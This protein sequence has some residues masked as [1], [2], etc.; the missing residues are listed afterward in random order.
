MV[1]EHHHHHNIHH[2]TRTAK[3]THFK[4]IGHMLITASHSVNR[5]PPSDKS[6]TKK[7]CDCWRLEEK[8][9]AS[10]VIGLEPRVKLTYIHTIFTVH[11]ETSTSSRIA[12]AYQSCTI[13]TP[14][15]HCLFGRPIGQQSDR[16]RS[17]GW[18]Q[19]QIE[20]TLPNGPRTKTVLKCKSP[21][22]STPTLSTRPTSRSVIA[23]L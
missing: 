8:A 9:N 13:W 15:S 17:V 19:I 2:H 12:I 3:Q 10:W 22:S 16:S 14:R 11:F 7:T 1:F 21:R 20:W 6:S 18:N 5:Q 23:G 4:W